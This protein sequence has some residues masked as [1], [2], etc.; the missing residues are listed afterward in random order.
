MTPDLHAPTRS[1]LVKVKELSPS[2]R[3]LL[4]VGMAVSCFLAICLKL[5]DE[6]VPLGHDEAVYALRARQ[7]VDGQP[8]GSW[9]APY[10]APGLPLLLRLAW[11][12]GGTETHLRAVVA[13]SGAVLIVGTWLVGRLM[14]GPRAAV[15]GAVGLALTP[16]V[17]SAATQV[18]TDVPGAAV[19]LLA[20]L[21]YAHG[22]ARERFPL[23]AVAVVPL[24]AGAATAI[25][26]G[27]PIVLAIGLVALTLWRPPSERQEWLRVTATAIAVLAV[28]G[29]LLMAGL[30]TEEGTPLAAISA[31][32][33]AQRFQ[34]F[35]DYW[36]VRRVLLAGPVGGGLVVIGAGVVASFLDPYSRRRFLWPLG[37]GLATFV[38]LSSSLQGVP[39]YLVPCYPW[40]WLAAGVWIAKFG[41]YLN[42]KAATA[43]AV[44]TVIPL[45]AVAPGLSDDRNRFNEV[46]V[47][48]REA[49]RSLDA[50]QVC[51]VTTGYAPQVEWY[52]RC[53]TTAFS[54]PD[55]GNDSSSGHRSYFLLVEGGKRQPE[56][57]ELNALLR[58]TVGTPSTYVGSGNALNVV[59]IW[60]V[61]G[62]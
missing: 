48:L 2:P 11:L 29:P 53:V 38:A 31:Q 28:V 1:G 7:L 9:W 15:A 5:I 19:A 25:R 42:A 14:V 21:V 16:L 54:R 37:I 61:G 62:P 24:L 6:G 20:L 26:F 4:V 3:E 57:S 34:G 39:H 33:A 44:L 40:V 13:L 41:S 23:W 50:G 46:F 35:V 51:T 56:D 43:V 27:E 36:N 58:Y 60:M 8:A 22:L 18:W 59:T 45:L 10:R 47:T 17:M 32:S 30:L 52:S 55:L 49:A 12:G